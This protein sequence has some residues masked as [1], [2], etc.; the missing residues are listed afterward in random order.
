M[1]LSAWQ[2]LRV[3]VA[4]LLRPRRL[5]Y[6]PLDEP[7]LFTATPRWL[8]FLRDDP[9]SLHRATARFLAESFRLDL[10]LR[11]TPRHVR[12]PVLLFLAGQDRII[13]NAPTRTFVERFA[14]GD[15]QV[16]EYAQAHHTL[17]F[18]PDPAPYF[19]DLAGWLL[20]HAG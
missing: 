6:V 16:I 13:D 9:L 7:E 11:G 5:F 10:Y 15:R 17:E 4:R 8:Q 2:K 3:L 18:E 1:R 14:S 20:R 12:V 19:A